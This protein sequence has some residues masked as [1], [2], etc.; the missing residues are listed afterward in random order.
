MSEEIDGGVETT[1]PIWPVFGDLMSVLLGAFVL[2]LVGVIGVQLELST[3]LEQEVKQRQVETQRRKTLEQALA[4]PLAAGRVTLVNG[5]IGI[6]GNV[7]FALNSDQLQPEGRELL[8][9]LAGPLTAYLHARD[10]ILMVSGF[11]DDRQVREANRRFTDNWELSAQ[12]ALTVTRALIDDGVP[13]ASVF[14]AAFGSQQPVGSN[15]DDQGRAKNRRV[16]IAPV[17]GPA[18]AAGKARE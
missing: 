3:K 4:G 7:L 14:A 18:N 9:S 15:A 1:A 13:A 2:I 10:E 11:T 12:R 5:R 17:P 8:K 16:E 6:S